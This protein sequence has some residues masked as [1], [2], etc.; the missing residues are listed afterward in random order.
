ME[1]QEIQDHFLQLIKSTCFFCNIEP[2]I[3]IGEGKLSCILR[4]TPS[5]DRQV[6]TAFR[7]I[8]TIMS[9]SGR[10]GKLPLSARFED[11]STCADYG[12]DIQGMRHYDLLTLDIPDGSGKVMLS[13][14]VC[15]ED[16]RVIS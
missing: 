5:T 11:Q 7:L 16:Y 1:L 4:R 10:L 15:V 9:S 13:L 8:Y 3:T 2:D 6:S 14:M 12:D